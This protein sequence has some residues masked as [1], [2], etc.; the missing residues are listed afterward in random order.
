M[1]TQRESAQHE[2]LQLRADIES[3]TSSLEAENSEST[4]KP[5]HENKPDH[6]PENTPRM[7]PRGPRL[8]P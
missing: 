8:G 4:I 7:P 3:Y 6:E 1:K 5:E 2:L